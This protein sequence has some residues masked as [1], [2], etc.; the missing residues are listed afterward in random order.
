[1]YSL[2]IPICTSFDSILVLIINRYLC[3]LVNCCPSYYILVNYTSNLFSP[4]TQLH[5]F[6][7]DKKYLQDYLPSLRIAATKI[8]TWFIQSNSNI[9]PWIIFLLQW[10]SVFHNSC[11]DLGFGCWM[12]IRCHGHVTFKAL[13]YLLHMLIL[14]EFMQK[15]KGQ[16]FFWHGN[17]LIV[18]SKDH[19]YLKHLFS[20][21]MTFNN[22][23]DLINKIILTPYHL[24]KYKC[25]TIT[26]YSARD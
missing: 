3:A 17:I 25:R 4:P 2:L 24:S 12:K 6:C 10:S 18:V 20:D 22:D 23:H 5:N 8:S 13:V 14:F 26:Q 1:M 11:V 19:M 7:F 21:D 15:G 16:E 9:N